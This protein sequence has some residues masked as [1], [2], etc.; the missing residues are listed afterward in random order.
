[1][2][3]RA[4]VP[5]EPRRDRGFQS[6]LVRISVFYQGI[7]GGSGDD[8]GG[9][10]GGATGVVVGGG[11]GGGAAGAL[12]AGFAFFGAAF[13]AFF[14]GAFFLPPFFLAAFFAPF[15]FAAPFFLAAFFFAMPRR[16]PS[17]VV[18]LE[19]AMSCQ[20]TVSSGER[21]TSGSDSSCAS[22]TL[23]HSAPTVYCVERRTSFARSF[24]GSR[25]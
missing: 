6:R 4:P 13:L 14:A 23:S 9:A 20:T 1:M 2:S 24:A 15:F 25:T 19:L 7:A 21:V 22:G 18:L 5:D 16:L 8:G 17:R 12:A 11:G 3:I 10:G